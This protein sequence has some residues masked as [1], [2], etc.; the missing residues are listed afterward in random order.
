TDACL[1]K[2]S[3]DPV[4]LHGTE[5]GR[6]FATA[7]MATTLEVYYRYAR[8]FVTDGAPPPAVPRTRE[9]EARDSEALQD[10]KEEDS[11]EADDGL[12]AIRSRIRTVAGKTFTLRHDG[13]WIDTTWDG[14]LE[15]TRIE[16]FSTA[17]FELMA[18]G[19]AVARYLSVGDR[20]LLVLD[21]KA[22]EVTPAERP[23][24]EDD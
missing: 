23:P 13:M 4:G 6:V 22:Y 2:G 11:A 8:G 17:Y 21:G 1:Y 10:L 18:R 3:W 19:E 20:V 15:P 9:Q 12:D 16:A 24:G 14:V 7:L 5:G